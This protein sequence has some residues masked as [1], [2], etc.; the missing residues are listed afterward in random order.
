MQVLFSSLSVNGFSFLFMIM[1]EELLDKM[2]L[3]VPCRPYLNFSLRVRI[4]EI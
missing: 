2:K 4:F 3:S 1:C